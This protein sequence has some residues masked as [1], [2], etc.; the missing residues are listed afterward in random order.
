MKSKKY[1][2]LGINHA[3]F[4]IL[5][6]FLS[7]S[8]LRKIPIFNMNTIRFHHTIDYKRNP[9]KLDLLDSRLFLSSKRIA[10]PLISK[11]EK[12][13]GLVYLSCGLLAEVVILYT[14]NP[15]LKAS[16]LFQ[17]VLFFRRRSLF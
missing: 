1:P 16:A 15:R 17:R 8:F 7:I 5:F 11:S 14:V 4:T 6:C 10:W 2:L 3:T 12:K 13:Y 9:I